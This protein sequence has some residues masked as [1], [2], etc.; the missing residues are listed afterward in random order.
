MAN[1]YNFSKI[2]GSFKKY[3]SSGN[4]IL[5]RSTVKNY[6]SDLR[7][8]LG[9]YQTTQKPV[10]NDEDPASD[11]VYLAKLDTNSVKDYITYLETTNNSSQTIKRRVSSLS[12]FLKYAVHNGL[13]GNNYVK[14]LKLKQKNAIKREIAP[15]LASIQVEADVIEANIPPNEPIPPPAPYISAVNEAKNHRPVSFA[16][17]GFFAVLSIVTGLIANFGKGSQPNSNPLLSQAS[18][19]SAR[20]LTFKG[21]LTDALGNPIDKK[22]DV[23]FKLYKSPGGNRAVFESNQCTVYPDV[24]GNFEVAIGSSERSMSVIGCD[25]KI[26]E[27]LFSTTTPLYMGITVGQNAEMKPRQQISNVGLADSAL[28]VSGMVLGTSTNNIPYIDKNGEIILSGENAS[29]NATGVSEDFKI[30]SSRSLMLSSA[31]EGDVTLSASQS[32]KLRFLTGGS[33]IDRMVIAA[34]GNVGIGNINPSFFKLEVSGSVGPSITKT[35][36]LGAPNRMWN[37]L[38]VNRICFD[39]QEKNCTTTMGSVGSV[40]GASTTA[41]GSA[42]LTSSTG[43]DLLVGSTA[44][45]SANI[46]L[47]GTKGN[48][49]FIRTGYLGVNTTSPTSALDVMGT[50]T[51]GG[52]VVDITT[53]SNEDLTLVANGNGIINLNDGVNVSGHFVSGTGIASGTTVMDIAGTATANALCHGTQ[54]GTDNEQ[55]VDCSSTPTADFAEMYPVQSGTDYGQ[56]MSLGSEEVRTNDGDYIRKLVPATKPNDHHLIGVVSNNYGD[57]ISVGHNLRKEDNPMPIALKGRIPVSIATSSKP[58]KAGDYL[59]SSTEPGKATKATRAGVMIGKA[60]EDWNPELGKNQIMVFVG[61]NYGDP[62]TIPES[63]TDKMGAFIGLIQ[64][65]IEFGEKITSPIVETDSIIPKSG[66]LTIDISKQASGSAKP[67]KIAI[68]GD[69]G[70]EVTSIDARGNISTEGSLAAKDASLTGTLRASEAS[71]SGTLTADRIEAENIKEL[72]NRLASSVQRSTYTEDMN[73]IQSTLGEIKNAKLPSSEL[74]P[75][76]PQGVVA[77]ESMVA[78]LDTLTVTGSANLFN[79]NVHDKIYSLNNELKISALASI[80]FMDGAIVMTRDG[81]ITVKG[82]LTAKE[83]KATKFSVLNDEGRETASIDAS[84]A[85]RLAGISLPSSATPSAIIA[86][87]R[88]FRENGVLMPA[89]ESK[90]EAAGVGV[91][92]EDEA[93]VA[94]YN[95]RLQN[96]TLIFLTPINATQSAPLS[97]SKKVTCENQVSCRPYFSVS[98]GTTPHAAIQFNWFILNSK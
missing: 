24:E 94:I 36:N 23:R 86:S 97:V 96:D 87:D 41:S 64:S 45:D 98:A 35:Y 12:S 66:N 82:T 73:S 58:I 21:R 15:S 19:K 88:N 70:R 10:I 91:I 59:T 69:G 25:K 92:P 26:P 7:H 60:L 47:A 77:D 9:W 76:A 13:I 14:E 48:T 32:G 22:T 40:L 65:P 74:Y 89:I 51:F 8:F 28:S 6:I 29:L 78:L 85:A 34:N 84:G 95:E 2:E 5:G 37:T 93:E 43:P 72:E 90:K 75:P 49:S 16:L 39:E 61:T 42:A 83:V 17:I 30:T 50:A 27:S 52:N 55:I 20:V 44:T 11:D 68:K 62:G 56:V 4:K 53:H 63:L 46:K 81:N 57:F 1:G 71:V 54:S 31:A 67:S 79:L 38:Y 80:N 18:S 33:E 3:I